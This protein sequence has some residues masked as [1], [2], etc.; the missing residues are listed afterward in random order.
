MS[1]KIKIKD[2][3]R[4]A[5]T[6]GDVNIYFGE[7]LIAG[8]SATSTATLATEGLFVDEDIVVQFTKAAVENAETK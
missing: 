5:V 7:T 2:E 8:L 4:D 3:T 1:E 6:E